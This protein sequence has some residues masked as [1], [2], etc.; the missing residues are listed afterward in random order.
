MTC[1]RLLLLSLFTSTALASIPDLN[2]ALARCTV[3]VSYN[4]TCQPLPE[5][6]MCSPFFSSNESV[7]IPLGMSQSDIEYSVLAAMGNVIRSK[8]LLSDA[9][10]AYT[11]AFICTTHYFPCLDSGN[12]YEPLPIEPCAHFCADY[13]NACNVTFF[14]FWSQGIT[15]PSCSAMDD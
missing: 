10:F 3:S 13:W 4:A 8:T 11:T 9:C 6:S 14:L 2:A 1:A 7:Y 5:S 12:R 15:P